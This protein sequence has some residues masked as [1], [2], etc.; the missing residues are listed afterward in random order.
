MTK[1]TLEQFEK[2]LSRNEGI[3]LEFKEAKN[4]LDAKQTLPDYCAALAN[5]GGGKLILG[6]DDKGKVVGTKA[7]QGTDNKLAHELFTKIKIRVDVEEFLHEDGRVLIFHVPGR[8]VGQRVKSTGKYLYP[9]RMGDSLAEMDDQK[10]RQIFN[11]TQ[12]DF[13]AGV[14][15]GLA[16]DDLYQPAIEIFRQK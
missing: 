12:P 8:Q 14:F 15:A 10:T 13:T 5:E 6:V 3:A 11:E 2:W 9:M 4:G 7:F 16:M 1:T